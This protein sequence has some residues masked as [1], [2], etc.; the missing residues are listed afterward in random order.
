MRPR[1][2]RLTWTVAVAFSFSLVGC[3]QGP[4]P[5]EVTT[6]A[7]SRTD[8]LPEG[9]TKTKKGVIKGK[10]DLNARKRVGTAGIDD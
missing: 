7:P 10:M 8:P 4:P 2:F 5:A 1:S 6:K 3:T 9:L